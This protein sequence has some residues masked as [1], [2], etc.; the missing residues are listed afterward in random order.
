MMRFIFRLMADGP[1][2]DVRFWDCHFPNPPFSCLTFSCPPSS[3]RI[4]ADRKMKDRKIAV[5][6]IIAPTNKPVVYS[7]R[8]HLKMS[9]CKSL[10]QRN[11]LLSAT[12]EGEDYDKSQSDS[13]V[14]FRVDCEHWRS[15]CP[16]P[17]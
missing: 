12:N 5:W 17:K 9:V 10:T 6:R 3:C 13:P 2:C 16:N 8:F 1:R 14:R 11:Q 15:H 7:T 4:S